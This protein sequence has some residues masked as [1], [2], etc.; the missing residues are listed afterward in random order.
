MKTNRIL[1]ILTILTLIIS[2]C[3]A[4]TPTEEPAPVVEPTEAP[5]PT[6]EPAA[7]E[8]VVVKIGI[9]DPCGEVNSLDPI[10]Q[11][12]AECSVMVNQIYNRL[13]DMDSNFQIMPELAHSWEANEDKTEWTFFL[14][15]VDFPCLKGRGSCG[16]L[17]D[18]EELKPV[19][20]GSP[21]FPI[22]LVLDKDVGLLHRFEVHGYERPRAV[23]LVMDVFMGC[24]L[25]DNPGAFD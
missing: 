3:T 23:A 9:V 5:E 24:A 14:N 12:G 1:L 16:R 21:F 18:Q 4:A 13:V 7:M 6:E 25:G 15:E 8:E 17:W 20:L 2:A 19:C 22:I 11:P 10:N